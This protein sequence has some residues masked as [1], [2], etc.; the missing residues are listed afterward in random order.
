MIFKVESIKE[1]DS[2]RLT[3]NIVSRYPRCF[4][5]VF[6]IIDTGSPRT[7][8]SAK[9]AY[10]L[11]IPITNFQDAKDIKGFGKGGLPCKKIDKFKFYIKSEDNQIRNI[12]MPV[13]VVDIVQLNNMNKDLKENAYKIP[14]IIGLDFLKS[15]NLKL[16]V[17]LQN[18]SYFQE[19]NA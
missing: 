1:P 15:Q 17:D 12:E 6:T 19:I 18:A 7:I 10:L 8:I 3:F 16:I 4:G 9:D 13:Y 11:K 2:E 5:G 14:S